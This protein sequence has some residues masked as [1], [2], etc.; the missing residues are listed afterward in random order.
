MFNLLEFLYEKEL[1]LILCGFYKG[2]FWNF[3][4]FI[5]KPRV[6]QEK[7]LIFDIL[8]VAANEIAETF[9]HGRYFAKP[10]ISGVKTLPSLNVTHKQTAFQ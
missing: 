10:L 7:I 9:L 2:K 8:I 1:N 3:S 6:Y 5:L 4:K